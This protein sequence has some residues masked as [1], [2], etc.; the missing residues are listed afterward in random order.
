VHARGHEEW[1]VRKRPE[2][3]ISN[4]F[5]PLALLL[6]VALLITFLGHNSAK[7]FEQTVVSHTE[8]YLLTIAKV[9][10]ANI[11]GVVKDI[12]AELLLLSDNPILRQRVRDKVLGTQIPDDAYFPMKAIYTR[13]GV[14]MGALYRLDAQGIVQARVPFKAG[15]EGADYSQNPGIKEF[16]EGNDLQE[17]LDQTPSEYISE[18]F[19]TDTGEK[20]FSIAI[21]VYDE[22]IRIGVLQALMYLD[23]VNDLVGGIKAGASGYAQVIDDD[24]FMLAHPE[25][26]QIGSDVLR[27]RTEAVPEH[28]WRDMEDL[29]ERMALGEEG[30]GVYHSVWWHHLDLQIVKKLTAF[31]PIRLGHELWSL[32]V[33]MGYDEIAEPI[34]AQRRRETGTAI[35]LMAALA[36]VGFWLHRGERAKAMLTMKA[37]TAEHLQKLNKDLSWE[38]A[39]LK[40][41]EEALRAER[42]YSTSIIDGTPAIVCRLLPDGN[43]SFLNAAG[44]RITGYA[45][46]E[47]VGKDWM[48]IL[49]TEEEKNQITALF[50]Q[51]NRASDLGHELTLTSK[52][53]E[54]RTL[55]WSLLD[56]VNAEG[57]I[58]EI[59]GIGQDVTERKRSEE[60]RLLLERQMQ[61]TQ[62]LESLG[63]LAGGIAHDF[64]NLLMVILGNT[65]MVLQSLP[66]SSSLRPL[67]KEIDAASHQAANLCRQM[68]AYSGQGQFVVGDINLN[69]TVE[70]ITSLLKASIGKKTEVYLHLKSDLPA[71]KA[72]AA[73]IQQVVMNL[74]T[75]ASEALGDKQGAITISSDVLACNAEYL[76]Q[77][78]LPKQP[79]PGD[80]VSLEVA[81]TGCGMNAEA[82]EKL[83]EPF[84]TTKF[85]GRG[86]GLAAV[87]GIVRGHNG[88]IVVHSKAGQGTAFQLLFPALA[89]AARKG[90]EKKRNPSNAFHGTGTVLVVD[91]EAMVR[92]IS[93][94]MLEKTGFNVLT[95][96]DGEHALE[97]YSENADDVICVILDLTMPRMDG[98]Q[99]L[100]E[101]RRLHEDVRVILAS[102]YSEQEL[103]ERFSGSGA[104]AFLQKPYRSADLNKKLKKVLGA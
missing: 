53:G 27:I 86:L 21:P 2:L 54:K 69:E 95:A 74:I 5:A 34:A 61:H 28:D 48:K 51:S 45:A 93:K 85:I 59:I 73:Q 33:V 72:D 70:E 66:E 87:L 44:E 6:L 89:E 12:H 15:A 67:M 58:A 49:Y 81:D 41:T 56:H 40:K 17:R 13:C 9:G 101:L 94:R 92:D 100:Q 68:L 46:D 50:Q 57:R 4:A 78:R 30:T 104:A 11:E 91:D 23:I 32:S 84:Y 52:A 10:A 31:V 76:R 29:L 103:S 19:E 77:S 96:E 98:E 71:I 20:A 38:T 90:K 7:E 26:E 14:Y 64:N 8:K 24:G 102:G 75:N 82:L 80:F 1:N 62:K 79:P 36:G 22:G 35:L 65:D 25:K 43:L 99:C 47:L 63:V 83:F 55:V 37:E 16:L 60:D 3:N 97:V 42:D 18:V 39:E 88:A